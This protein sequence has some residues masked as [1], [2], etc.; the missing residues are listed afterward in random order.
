M[1]SLFQLL[2][3]IGAALLSF[4]LV[5]G[6]FSMAFTEDGRVQAMIQTVTSTFT[7]TPTLPQ[8][9]TSVPSGTRLPQEAASLTPA[10]AFT[11]EETLPTLAVECPSPPPGWSRIT[12]GQGDTLAGLAQAY[13]TSVEALRQANCLEV[14]SLKPGGTLFVPGRPTETPSAP[15]GPPPIGFI[16][17]SNLGT[18]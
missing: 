13:G 6:S 14:D 17:S 18:L 8:V 12:I 3:G 16:I 11:P 5:L 9:E 4:V 2:L 1:K 7:L 10:V 15:C